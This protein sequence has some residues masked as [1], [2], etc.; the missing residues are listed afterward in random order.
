M[1][2]LVVE[3]DS[4]KMVYCKGCGA[5]AGVPSKCTVYQYGEHRFESTT[6]PVICKGCGAIPGDSTKCPVYQYGE[7]RFNEVD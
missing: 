6:V 5:I 4:G 1:K 2:I 3:G 7:H